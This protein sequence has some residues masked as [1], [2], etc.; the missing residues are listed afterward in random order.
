[1]N[2]NNAL[3][4]CGRNKLVPLLALLATGL[5]WS[6][7]LQSAAFVTPIPQSTK[8]VDQED[9]QVHFFSIPTSLPPSPAPSKR[10]PL[11]PTPTPPTP[12][13]TTS[14]EVESSKTSK[15]A[16]TATKPKQPKAKSPPVVRKP[17]KSAE[18]LRTFK[19]FNAHPSPWHTFNFSECPYSRCVMTSKPLQ[20]DLIMAQAAKLKNYPLP[21]RKPGALL[22]MYTKEPPTFKRFR[23]LNRTDLMGTVNWTRTVFRDS[24][25][26]AFYGRIVS[27]SNEP[28]KDYDEIF[29]EK[30]LK[31]AWFVSHCETQSKRE[32]YVARLAKVI[33]V[34]IFGACGK[35]ACGKYGFEMGGQKESCMDM[36]SRDYKFYISFENSMCSDY[37]TEKLFNMYEDV[38]VIP[39]VRGGATYSEIAP[40]GT[41]VDA[42]DFSSPEELGNYLNILGSNKARYTEMLRKKNSYLARPVTKKFHC[43]VCEAMHTRRSVHSVVPDFLQWMTKHCWEPDDL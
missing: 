24:T 25:F 8:S 26:R 9:N 6:L 28:D 35:M 43:S 19:I 10:Q 41:Y 7:L 27:R 5:I 20:A 13:T 33:Q 15:P 32:D 21:P 29:R 1:M 18:S 12:P 2:C 14:L 34:D 38:D 31:V 3:T 36:L 22:L 17:P 30:H 11:L 16:A 4:L 42:K 23:H 37:V 39:V 40:K